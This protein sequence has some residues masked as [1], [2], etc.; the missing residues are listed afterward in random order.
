LIG[1][2]CDGLIPSHPPKDAVAQRREDA[3]KRFR[4]DYL[5]TILGAEAADTSAWTNQKKGS[6]K[7]RRDRK[8]NGYRPKRSG[9]D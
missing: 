8:S 2:G 1:D 3:K 4:G 6:K 9:A 7:Q 5:H